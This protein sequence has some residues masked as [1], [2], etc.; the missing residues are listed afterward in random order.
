MYLVTG[1]NGV[2]GKALCN[3][4]EQRGISVCVAVRKNKNE[5]SSNIKVIEIG[6][7][8]GKTDWTEALTGVEVILHL[9]AMSEVSQVT[10]DVNIEALF[11][12]VNVDG[13][14]HLAHMAQ[15]AGVRRFVYV[16]SISVN[17]HDSGNLWFD[18]SSIANPQGIYAQSKWEAEKALSMLVSEMSMEIVIT[19]SPLVYGAGISNN[20]L[21]LMRVINK[22]LP[23]P[24]GA[25]R[26]ERS[27]IYI[28]N[29]VDA[30]AL[31]A[32]HPNAAGKT[33]V[34][35]D[36]ET[37]STPQLIN[38]LSVLMHRPK[39]LCSMPIWM[40]RFF[41]K[42]CGRSE[43]VESMMATRKI[44]NSKI[45][46]ELGWVPPYSLDQGLLFMVDWFSKANEG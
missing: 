30:L 40:L 6:E 19:R 17:G 36:N 12:K 10:D 46:N 5:F 38:Q 33:Y 9:A 14:C 42:L 43:E 2:V 41:G 32:S 45:K 20:L 37:I 34:V 1:A 27:L 16:S 13:T 44:D 21:R 35:C 4:L 26:N 24:L 22:R 11:H 25:I 3:I 18:E 29:L 15:S 23:L 8:D 28:G 7:I 31:C 39:L